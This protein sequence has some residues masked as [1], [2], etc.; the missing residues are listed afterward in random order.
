MIMFNNIKKKN[1]DIAVM[2]LT[3]KIGNYINDY[4][5]YSF[6]GSELV[7]LDIGCGTGKRTTDYFK[8]INPNMR[9]KIIGLDYH[10]QIL[11]QTRKNNIIPYLFKFRG[12]YFFTNKK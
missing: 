9:Y 2:D 4:I 12:H 7:I 3:N 5:N 1:H 6:K 11:A 8:N 10:R